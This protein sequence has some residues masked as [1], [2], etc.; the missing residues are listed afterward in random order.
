MY[1]LRPMTEF[2]DGAPARLSFA[3]ERPSTEQLKLWWTDLEGR[4][5]PTFFLA[6]SWIGPWLEA[7]GPADFVVVGRAGAE[8]VFLGLLRRRTV[9]RHRLIRSRTLF[10]HQT[11]D[12]EQ[13]SVFIEHNGFLTDRRFSGITPAAFEFLRSNETLPKFDELQI[14]GAPETLY[15][16]FRSSGLRTRIF[17]RKPTSIVD[18]ASVRRAG[19]DYLASVSSNTRYQIRRALK[20]YQARGPLALHTART[21]EE[22][23]CFFDE[24]GGLH[25][26]AWRRRGH[27][28][29][30]RYPFLVGMQRRIIET[31]FAEG[32]VEIARISCAGEP[33]GYIYCLARGGWIGN[34]MSGFAFEEDNKVKPGLVSFYLYIQHRIETGGDVLDLLAGDQ[35]Y[36]A[37]LGE[38]GPTMIWFRVQQRR[39][40][41]MIEEALRRL[42]SSLR[43]VLQ[44]R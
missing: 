41:L 18:L 28:G 16:S 26:A 15:E 42:K 40:Q 5:D 12:P 43:A 10:L 24:L 36:K 39:P 35:R 13:D 37:S 38:P 21:T 2:A 4:A 25:E 44:R 32:G 22:A 8:V 19:G 6:W 11:G 33:I 9:R 29:A 27:D 1:K 20:I 23:L 17:D 30:W 34:Y 14:G 3:L 7:A 31:S